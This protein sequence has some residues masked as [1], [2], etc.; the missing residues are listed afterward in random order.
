MQFLIFQHVAEEHPG[1]FR[2]FF[3]DDGIETTAVELDE[4]ATIPDLSEFDALWVMGGPMDVW[5]E[6]EHPW[7][8]DEV[9]AIQHAV[10]DRKMPFMG[11]CLGHQ[12]LAQ[13]L[14]GEVGPSAQPEIGILD[15]TISETGLKSPLMQ[16]LSATQNCLQ[17]HSAEVTKLPEGAE[18]LASSP[19][20]QVQS[21]SYG[22]H[23][24]SMQFHVELEEDTVPNW[25]AIPEYRDA[26]AKSAAPG[27]LETMLA[28]AES[29]MPQF[30]ATS[31]ILY[32]NFMTATG[33]SA[34]N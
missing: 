34:A 25:A 32:N 21:L 3:K 30:N 9:A 4:G 17:W 16:G 8:I 28:R 14:G 33:L 20:C 22:G 12:L 27:T 29:N 2:K 7:L 5:Q 18:V 6:D 23:A 1:I 11:I 13:S 15:V 10:I 26:L 19:A 31:R 24:F